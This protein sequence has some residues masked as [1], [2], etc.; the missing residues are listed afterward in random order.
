M[1]LTLALLLRRRGWDVLYLGADIP[2]H[3]LALTLTGAQPNLVILAAQQLH[4]AASLLEL[5]QVLLDA[6][7]PLAFGGL[8]FNRLPGLADVI[9]GHFLGPQ[10]E[11]ALQ[12]LEQLVQTGRPALARRSVPGHY[13]AAL[14]HFRERRAQIEAE[15][16]RRLEQQGIPEPYLTNANRYLGRALS[17]ALALGDLDYLG[18]D[19]VW[20]DEL[21]A[22]HKQRSFGLFDC[23]LPAYTA[24]ARLHLG[25]PAQPVLDWLDRQQRPD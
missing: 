8:I 24:A 10:F 22:N 7:V 3:S 25:A 19:L 6:R 21:L 17:A 14:D 1:P 18:P 13:P 4:T 12:Q 9:P 15:V 11:A 2:V 23:Y 16:W 20:L 5:A